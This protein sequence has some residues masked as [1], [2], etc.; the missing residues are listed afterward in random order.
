MQMR[1]G[2]YGVWVVH[3]A[4]Q[5]GIADHLEGGPLSVEALATACAAD[6]PSL[7]RF[8]DTLEGYGLVAR[9]FDGRYE[10]TGTGTW[11]RGGIAGSLK[12]SALMCGEESFFRAWSQL[13]VAVRSGR[14]SFETTNGTSFFSFLDENAGMLANFQGAMTSFPY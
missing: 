1:G 2:S 8:L 6:A 7:A 13:A 5:L 11:L 4:A 12:A 10:L 9:L 14:P 3:A